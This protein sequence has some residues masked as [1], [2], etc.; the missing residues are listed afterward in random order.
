MGAAASSGHHD[1]YP[2]G[3]AHYRHHLIIVVGVHKPRPEMPAIGVSL[4]WAAV[5]QRPDRLSGMFEKKLANVLL[6][7]TVFV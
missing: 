2:V 6:A 7:P 5:S 3:G 4:G 1:V